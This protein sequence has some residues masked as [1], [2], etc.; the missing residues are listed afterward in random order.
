[1]EIEIPNPK[2]QALRDFAT[3]DARTQPDIRR[4]VDRALMDKYCPPTIVVDNGMKIIQF[5]G[6]VAP[7][8]DPEPGDASLD[9]CSMLRSSLE[10]LLR[11]T[12]NDAKKSNGAARKEGILFQDSG[13]A[14]FLDLEV[15]PMTG[16]AV[17]ERCFLLL[18]EASRV[19]VSDTTTLKSK[20]GRR[21][22]QDAQVSQL[23]QE[24]ATTREHLQTLIEEQESTNEELKSASEEVQSANEELQSTNEE[25]ETA[26]EELQSTNEELVTVNEQMQN[27]NMELAQLGDDLLN[28]L[29]GVNIPIVMLGNDLRIRRFT[30]L[31][32]RLLNLVPTDVGR[33]IDN[34]RPNLKF[35]LKNNLHPK[36][37]GAPDLAALIHE[38]IDTVSLKEQEVQD[39]DGRWYSMRLR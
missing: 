4:E 12:I 11:S 26:K 25:L 7:F 21:N 2:E 23:A 17:R 19:A 36:N 20:R 32:E 34:I 33:P 39:L 14:S 24:L 13:K 10:M 35:H 29:G 28:L 30:P 37:S 31:A 5:R 15:A 27:R 6:N 38:V 1:M 22:L 16:S 3:P 18:F 8:L 9:L